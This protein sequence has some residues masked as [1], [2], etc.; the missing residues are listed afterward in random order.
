MNGKQVFFILLLALGGFL[1]VIW[2]LGYFRVI[3]LF[4]L[5]PVILESDSSR[6]LT[7]FAFLVIG[8]GIF[9]VIFSAIMIYVESAR[10][11]KLDSITET[12]LAKMFECQ[13]TN[14]NAG[15]IHL[16]K[17]TKHQILVKQRWP[18][19]EK[20]FFRIPMRLMNECIPYFRDRIFRCFKCGQE[21]MVDHE[22]HS[23]PWTLIK[24][25]CPTHGNNLSYHKIWT[26]VYYDVLT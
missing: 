2:L 19:G 18:S 10:K 12:D 6:F 7:L 15:A 11:T 17:V 20:R 5:D 25:T 26:T 1:I 24:L 8:F 9:L 16:I 13:T 23:G 3:Y 4:F 22:K 21:S 14:G